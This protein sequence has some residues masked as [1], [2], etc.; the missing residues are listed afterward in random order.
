[1]I[2]SFMENR[3]A[4]LV[5]VLLVGLLI[6]VVLF[7]VVLKPSAAAVTTGL[8]EYGRPYPMP[9]RYYAE[10]DEF[11][12]FA[13]GGQQGG[14]FVYGIPSMKLLAE[15]P[16]FQ[17]L[18]QWGWTTEDVNVREM[19]TN[20]YTGELLERGDTHHP[21]VSRTIQKTDFSLCP[22]CPVYDGR[23][24]FIP[25]KQQPRV[26]RVDVETFRTG[27]I[28]WLPNIPGG[29]HGDHIN[30]NSDLFA[31][32][33]ELE[34]LP[35]QAIVD[36]V[37]EALGDVVGDLT[38]G[39]YLAGFAGIDVDN[40]TGEMSNAWQVWGPY[41]HDLLNIGWGKSE[42]WIVNTAYNTERA[43]STV[44]MF[45][46]DFDY[47]FIWN[48]DSIQ[49]AVADGK[50]ITTEQAPDVPILRYTDIEGYA[51]PIPLNPHG[52]NVTP[53]GKYAIVA[54]KAT[55]IQTAVDLEKVINECVPNG[56]FI[57]EAYS[58]P[59]V[60]PACAHAAQ[61]DAGLGSTH[62]EFDDQGFMYIAF[63]IDAAVKKITLGPP[64]TEL[65]GME[66]WK[67]VDEL[68]AHFSV[69]HL[70]I[71]GSDSGNPWG[72]Y[73]VSLNKLTKDTFLP[74]GPLITENHE[75]FNIEQI[76]AKL[77]DQMPLPP[78]THYAQGV[79]VSLIK[80]KIKWTYQLPELME[81]PSVEYD[82]DKQEVRVYMQAVRSW[83]NPE[84][85]TV[86]EGWTVKLKV[87]NIEEAK[88]MTHGFSLPGHNVQFSFDPGETKEVEYVAKEPGVY[89]YYCIWFC[90]ELHMEMRGRMI[91]VPQDEWSPDKETKL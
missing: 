75:L 74:H 8:T 66:P 24:V 19:L 78:E 52:V 51:V 79:P 87:L 67:V 45:G 70:V 72:K 73:V 30:G 48:I 14:L 23:W 76:P 64:Y 18:E 83:F 3:V 4:S 63:F 68:P 57:D 25:D 71:P 41:H 77:I 9:H 56:Q 22:T 7:G 86:P 43:T 26:A 91:V 36:Y 54:G 81:D 65:H 16:I 21:V 2:G 47:V 5:T 1:M 61:M 38:T 58:L 32:D 49:K 28:L 35:D 17:P 53:S 12:I 15:I 29:L 27:Q 44:P 33:F 85:F 40:K 42:G 69:G 88:D 89:W 60:D 50:Y 84:S 39:P 90:S 82:Y 6:G 55:T 20:P 59:V 31:V 62:I 46:S 37:E 11:Y 80:D 10:T 34:V 13:S